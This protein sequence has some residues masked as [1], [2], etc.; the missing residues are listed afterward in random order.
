MNLS[1]S[2]INIVAP[3]IVTSTGAALKKPSPINGGEV[4]TICVL[5]E[6]Q[7]LNILINLYCIITRAKIAKI[8][9]SGNFAPIFS[10]LFR[11]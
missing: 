3:P 5:L 11:K 2:K 6:Q 8:F 4:G 7:F 1:I 10:P 9:D